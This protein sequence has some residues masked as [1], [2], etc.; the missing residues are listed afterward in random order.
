MRPKVKLLT[1]DTRGIDGDPQNSG[2]LVTSSGR[3][4]YLIRTA[5]R[6]TRAGSAPN[7]PKFWRFS[8]EMVHKA[9]R[10]HD[11]PIAMLRKGWR[12]SRI[13]PGQPRPSTPRLTIDASPDAIRIR[14]KQETATQHRRAKA[15][16]SDDRDSDRKIPAIRREE[17]IADG[18][19]IRGATVE[20]D[21]WVDPDDLS[22]N[23]RT[24]RKI[25]GYRSVD[26]LVTHSKRN[27]L[28]TKR[29]IR[30]ANKLRSAHDFGVEGARIGYVRDLIRNEGF[31]P[32]AGPQ[33]Q[34]LIRLREYED[35]RLMLGP[36]YGILHH[37]AIR[38]NDVTTY[39]NLGR[40]AMGYLV[41]ALDRLADHYFPTKADDKD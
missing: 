25:T 20:Q 16:L 23:R 3:I 1:I 9:D 38:N 34:Q 39:R 11:K 21:E 2:Y 6:V 31:A 33:E 18:R 14:R 35:T 36:L 40:S 22:P 26:M 28:I 4:S 7:A 10:Q 13:V 19:T 24:A 5:T 30:A 37:V 29:H 32:G 15:L 27:S 17:I 12:T 8:L 41:A